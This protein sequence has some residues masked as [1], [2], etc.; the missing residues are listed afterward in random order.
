MSITIPGTGFPITV[1]SQH[2]TE[3]QVAEALNL[4]VRTCNDGA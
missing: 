1:I 4:S 2:L 3:R